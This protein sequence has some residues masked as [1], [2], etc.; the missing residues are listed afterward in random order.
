MGLSGVGALVEQGK[1]GEGIRVAEDGLERRVH[2]GA[3]LAEDKEG[4]RRW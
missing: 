4:G 1:A 3:E 2:G